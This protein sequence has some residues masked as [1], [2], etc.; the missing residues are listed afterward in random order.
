MQVVLANQL[1]W[2]RYTTYLYKQDAKP[3]IIQMQSKLEVI[4]KTKYFKNKLIVINKWSNGRVAIWKEHTSLSLSPKTGWMIHTLKQQHSH[5]VGPMLHRISNEAYQPTPVTVTV[6]TTTPN[7]E[8]V[9]EMKSL[10]LNSNLFK[11]NPW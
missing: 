10:N 11:L 6:V 5:H 7:K 9:E 3:K 4:G 2:V 8:L 1:N